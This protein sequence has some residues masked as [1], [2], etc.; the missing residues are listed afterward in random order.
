MAIQLNVQGR[1]GNIM[2]QT[3]ALEHLGLRFGYETY[4]PN[5]KRQIEILKGDTL[6]TPSPEADDYF[7]IF[8]NFNWHN[9]WEKPYKVNHIINVPFAFE[10]M[11]ELD[12]NTLLKG[13]FQSENNWGGDR[14][15]VQDLFEPSD[16]VLEQLKKY[17]GL[18]KH[19]TCSIHVRR[20]DY[21]RFPDTHPT[22]TTDYIDRAKHLLKGH[23]IVNWIVFS[24]DIEWCKENLKGDYIFIENEKDYVEMFLMARCNYKIIAN[25]SFSW[26][27]AYLS[28]VG[29][30]VVAPIVW[31][32]NPK[33]DDSHVVPW[34][35][36]K[37]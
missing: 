4:Y 17:D 3:A 2:F 31:I 20:G 35:W 29:G 5:I 19:K 34:Y 30:E 21:L 25:S 8:K 32:A 26:F 36:L 16:M 23:K 22:V 33:V 1:L 24:D 13:Y 9:G 27:G 11:H 14:A 28:K 12:D 7:K 15:W 10:H 37:I 6:Y 18:F